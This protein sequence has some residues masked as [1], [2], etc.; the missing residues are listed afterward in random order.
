M[1]LINS[2]RLLDRRKRITTSIK[3][4]NYIIFILQLTRQWME[5]IQDILNDIGNKH[6]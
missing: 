5:K 1:D 4:G 3:Y 6:V 2:I